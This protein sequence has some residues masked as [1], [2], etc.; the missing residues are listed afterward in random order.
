MYVKTLFSHEQN[1]YTFEE[2]SINYMF[3]CMST[4]TFM[5]FAFILISEQHKYD[6]QQKIL[7]VGVWKK[8]VKETDPPTLWKTALDFMNFCDQKL[9]SCEITFSSGRKDSAALTSQ[10]AVEHLIGI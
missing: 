10:G 5:A 6:D 9:T 8:L 1:R 7:A 2:K 4:G 3:W